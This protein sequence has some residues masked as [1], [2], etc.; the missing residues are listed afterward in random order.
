M[1]AHSARE[2]LTKIE[3]ECSFKTELAATWAVR[4][5]AL[6]QYNKHPALVL[7]NP[8]GEPLNR[9]IQGPMEMRRFLRLVISFAGALSRLHKQ[10]L[11]HKDRRPTPL[12]FLSPLIMKVET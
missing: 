11:I 12:S 3:H 7:E 2:G 6:S 1:A 10:E 8:G 9:L 4:P 5:L